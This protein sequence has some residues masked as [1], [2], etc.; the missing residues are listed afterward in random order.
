MRLAKQA[1]SIEGNNL[2]TK[3]LTLLNSNILL[4][5]RSQKWHMFFVTIIVIPV[6]IFLPSLNLPHSVLLAIQRFL[7]LPYL[8]SSNFY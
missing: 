5:L 8:P 6:L 4:T 2:S 1:M 3:V 7:K